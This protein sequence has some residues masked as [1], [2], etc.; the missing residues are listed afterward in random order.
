[1]GE[2]KKARECYETALN[3]NP[4]SSQACAGLGELFYLEGKDKE[5]K[6]MYEYAVKYNPG[7]Q[8]AVGGLEKINRILSL[9]VD[10]NTLLK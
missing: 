6:S 8:F 1:M 10:D 4:D 7:N 5:A 2:N 9:P 3:I